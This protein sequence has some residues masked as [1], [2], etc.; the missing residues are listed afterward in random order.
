MI[1]IIILSLIT[2]LILEVWSIRR[3]IQVLKLLRRQELTDRH[4]REKMKSRKMLYLI[5]VTGG[6]EAE[7]HGPYD[8]DEQRDEQAAYI[9]NDQDEGEDSLFPLD[10]SISSNGTVALSIDCYSGMGMDEIKERWTPK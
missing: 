10:L 1:L 6:V 9:A 7:L 2:L 3:I 4:R 5:S 8:K